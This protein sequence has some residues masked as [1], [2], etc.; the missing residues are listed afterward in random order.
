MMVNHNI[1]IPETVDEDRYLIAGHEVMYL[2]IAH[3]LAAMIVVDYA[4]NE[5]I[6]PY[7]KKLRDSGVSI[8]VLP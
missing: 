1:E 7:L 5:Q 3:K 4:P 6:R 2:G 8:L